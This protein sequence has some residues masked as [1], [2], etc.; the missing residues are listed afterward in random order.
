MRVF[1]FLF[2][3]NLQL[4]YPSA[5]QAA[6]GL[7]LDHY[8]RQVLESNPTLSASKL[9]AD[10]AN[11]RIGAVTSWQDPFFALGIDEV[12][13]EPPDDTSMYRFQI[14][15]TVPFPGKT[16]SRKKAAE[17]RAIQ[18]Q[19]G[20]EALT[21]ET[22]IL[23]TQMFFRAYYAQ[24]GIRLSQQLEALLHS[25][26]ES[27]KSRY[28]AGGSVHHELL[29]ARAE[30]SI[31]SVEKLRLERERE[32]IEVRLNELRSRPAE[33]E[34][35]QVTVVFSPPGKQADP[36]LVGQPELQALSAMQGSAE[37]EVRSARL[38][39]F[40][41][42]VLQGMLMKPRA[43]DSMDA[44]MPGTRFGLMV[45]MSLPL[46]FFSKQAKQVSAAKLEQEAM[47]FEALA[48]ENRLR[49]EISAA[50]Q[51]LKSAEDAIGLYQ[52]S[53]VPATRLAAENARTGYAAGR[54]P[55]SDYLSI[56]RIQ[57][58]QELELLAT[59][60]DRELALV[61]LENLLSM[62]PMLRFAP[63]RPTLFMGSGGMA[64]G[65][66]SGMESSMDTSDAVDMGGGMRNVKPPQTESSS[67]SDGVG[68]MEGM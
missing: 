38:A 18:A 14:S 12:P 53:V 34:I 32:L 33:H 66:M 29:L 45:G 50:R 44:E 22:K 28:R 54:V 49:S 11:E 40:P 4:F 9:R 8:L 10:A 62:P 41:D 20:S 55:L 46:F 37:A 48:L 13:F 64:A 25:T 6:E 39:Y 31:L 17:S 21:R 15:Q 7:S 63:T 68:A 56:I 65:S 67:E 16:G 43:M 30:L 58:T 60:I 52:E 47:S 36:D 3:F 51:S 2:C 35:G 57:R 19:S 27:L 5:G 24:E 59:K 23:A 42:F 1:V 26:I 61:R